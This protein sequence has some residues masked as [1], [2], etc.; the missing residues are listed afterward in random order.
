MI[1]PTK[2]TKNLNR[3]YYSIINGCMN[4]IKGRVKFKNFRILLESGFSSTTVMGKLV[5][6]TTS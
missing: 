3:H 5:E 1:N 2:R 6:K 4:T